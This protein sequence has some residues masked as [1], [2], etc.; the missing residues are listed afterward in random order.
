MLFTV[1]VLL[2]ATSDHILSPIPRTCALLDT[3]EQSSLQAAQTHYTT[4]IPV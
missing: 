3:S 4:F 1:T 2:L